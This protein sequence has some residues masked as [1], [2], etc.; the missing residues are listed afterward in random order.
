MN[1]NSTNIR[2]QIHGEIQ[3][4][5]LYFGSKL[6]N[7]QTI[8]SL[9]DELEQSIAN[10]LQ[11]ARSIVSERQKIIEQSQ[12]T[13]NKIV[14]EANKKAQQMIAENA[15]TLEA[16]RYYEAQT[17]SAKIEA[18]RIRSEA[19]SQAEAIVAEATQTAMNL[20]SKT[21]SYIVDTCS[22]ILNDLMHTYEVTK[23]F[24]ESITNQGKLITALA[25]K[26]QTMP[27]IDINLDGEE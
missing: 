10:D 26:I 1:S 11:N 21:N 19:H 6:V 23:T 4:S 14:T 25:Q 9:L 12:D 2:N 20:K 24:N 17:T 7:E 8:N 18:D 3:K 27:T 16:Q 15:I 22:K 5:R 13:A